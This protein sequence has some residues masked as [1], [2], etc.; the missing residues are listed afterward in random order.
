MDTKVLSKPETCINP[1]VTVLFISSD[2]LA[3]VPYELMCKSELLQKEWIILDGNDFD[4][5]FLITN[6][7]KF[8]KSII[9]RCKRARK[10][11]IPFTFKYDYKTI[12]FN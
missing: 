11:G 3:K 1:N 12:I 9:K 10:T 8:L 5:G 6:D 4:G 2:I 7:E